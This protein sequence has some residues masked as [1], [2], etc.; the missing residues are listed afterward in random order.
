MDATVATAGKECQ[1]G[2]DPAK[3]L[4]RFED[5]Y[6]HHDLLADA[7]GVE[8]NK[9]L[10][11]LLLW[12]GKEFRK[13]A[14]DAGVVSEGDAQDALDAAV[15]KVWQSCQPFDGNFQADA[16]AEKKDN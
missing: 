4:E 9:K 8:A 5:W 13:F 3:F 12:G 14:K 11:L 16:K 2:T 6:E 1:L 10:K 15:E 7:V